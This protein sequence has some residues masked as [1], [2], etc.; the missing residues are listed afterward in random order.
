MKRLVLR[1]LLLVFAAG[2]LG[3]NTF[4]QPPD[5]PPENHYKVYEVDDIPFMENL[6]LQDQFLEAGTM[7]LFLDKFANPV[8]KNGE[9]IPFP[10]RHHDW[11]WIDPIPEVEH[12]VKIENQFGVQW[13]STFD[14]HY[15]VVPAL[16]SMTGEP[17]GAPPVANH[18]LAYQAIGDAIDGVFTL[19]DQFGGVEVHQLRPVY[20]LNP[21][22]KTRPGQDPEDIQEEDA[23]LACYEF[24]PNPLVMRPWVKD[25]FLAGQLRTTQDCWLCVPS[26]KR[27]VDGQVETERSTWGS[28][29]S[30]Y[31]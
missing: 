27:E 10:D 16:K 24:D 19:D 12:I 29:K 14:A 26:W 13:W 8:D 30:L 3:T 28:V 9:G 31:K 20:W 23:H 6:A 18:Y 21:V 15:L 1:L 7:V 25:Q 2:I 17:Q 4:A 22:R 11:Y 5:W